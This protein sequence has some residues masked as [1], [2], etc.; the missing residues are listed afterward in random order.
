MFFGI[1]D[2]AARAK[3]FDLSRVETEFLKDLRVVLAKL[4]RAPCRLLFKAVHLHGESAIACETDYLPAGL[5][6]L[7]SKR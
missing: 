7:Q 5:A 3:A 6:F 1:R 4:G 2:C